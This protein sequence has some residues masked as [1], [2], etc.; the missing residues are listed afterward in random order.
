MHNEHPEKKY[1]LST[2]FAMVIGNVIGSGVFFKAESVLRTTGGNMPMGIAAWLL[3]GAIMLVCC[4][5]FA[6]MAARF[7]ADGGPVGYAQATVGPRYAYLM[8]WFTAVI[9]TPCLVSAVSWV[10][11]RYVCVLLGWDIR[12][13]AAMTLAAFF[14]IALFAVNTLAPRLGGPVQVC[15]TAVKLV[16]LVGMALVGTAVGLRSG[17]LAENFATAHTAGGSLMGAS[18]SVAF[19]YEGWLLAT[20]INGE[21]RNAKRNLPIALVGGACVVVG[22]YTLY[23]VGL[24]GAVT[25]AEMMESGQAAAKLAFRRVFGELAG[26][27]VFLL[28]V[29][30]CLGT[31]NGMTISG[32]RSF[33]ALGIRGHG[34][35]PRHMAQVDPVTDI[36]LLSAVAALLADVVWLVYF[37]GAT[38]NGGWWGGFRFDSSE[39]PVITL[40]AMYVPMFLGLMGRGQGLN[41]WKRWI[42]PGLGIIGCGFMVYAAFAGYGAPTV[43]RY[44]VVFGV[45]MAVG[46][47]FYRNNNEQR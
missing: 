18:V 8:G 7:D 39:L 17:L 31:L 22:I 40:Y 44:L 27:G 37:Y 33:Y 35:A 4:Y 9:Y 10:A 12:G 34:P 28:V 42:A 29:V 5:V 25:T 21:L 30:S 45:L 41:P 19:A 24:S 36:P 6:T 16:P 26:T 11:A 14:L 46:N 15:S 2:A 38:V 13:G 3:V 47:L 1:G 32:C 23:Y 20:S 43:V